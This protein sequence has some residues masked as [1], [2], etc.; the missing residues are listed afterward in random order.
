LKSDRIYLR[1]ILDEI[2]FL[3]KAT[4]EVDYQSFLGNDLL[5][6]ASAR[7]IEI[8]GEATKNLSSEF[9][10]RHKEIEWK[11]FAGMRDKVIHM[12]FGVNWIIVWDVITSVLPDVKNR[13]ERILSEPNGEHIT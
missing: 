7:S 4:G 12:Y 6:R 3:L 10:K 1:H 11:Q 9:R 5:T 13:I 8:I 2:D